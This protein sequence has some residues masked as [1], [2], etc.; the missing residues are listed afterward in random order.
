MDFNTAFDRLLAHEG[1]Y[2]NDPRDA[3]GETRFGISARAYP[4]ENIA[5]MTIERAREIYRRDYWGPMQCEQMP[6]ALR[7]E[8]FDMAVNMGRFKA[9]TL[10]QD[11]VGAADDGILG[12]DTLRRLQGADPQWIL[13]RLQGARLDAYTRAKSWPVF[14][15]G[16]V[17]RVARNMMAG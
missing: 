12:P 4:Q 8:L 10:L 11:A 7:F 16:W 13:R 17:R 15:T 1:G 3:G 14:G 6:A 9:V 5:G 2:V